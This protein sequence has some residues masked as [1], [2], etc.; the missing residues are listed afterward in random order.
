MLNHLT[1]FARYIMPFPRPLDLEK[2]STE[3]IAPKTIICLEQVASEVPL[4]GLIL[5]KRASGKSSMI[6]ELIRRHVSKNEDGNVLVFNGTE[7]I[8]PIYTNLKNELGIDIE[9]HSAYN[10]EILSAFLSRHKDIPQK[11]FFIAFDNCFELGSSKSETLEKVIHSQ[12][13]NYVISADHPLSISKSM[14]HRCNY[15][16]LFKEYI[17]TYRKRIYNLWHLDDIFNSLEIFEKM[18]SVATEVPYGYL[19]VDMDEK[20]CFIGRSLTE[21]TVEEEE[22]LT[23]DK[24]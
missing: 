4:H 5:G 21:M 22:E 15:I 14:R 1:K 20:T 7:H 17:Y 9:V 19:L 2:G 24:V 13:M 12:K 23:I 3:I 10:E 8:Y 16:F 11:K 18:Y 6:V